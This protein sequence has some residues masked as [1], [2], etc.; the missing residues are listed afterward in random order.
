MIMNIAE[1]YHEKIKK[2]WDGQGQVGWK[3]DEGI[4]PF[5][6]E[7][8]SEYKEQLG[9]DILD[10][11][12]GN[13]RYMMPFVRDGFNVTGLDISQEMLNSSERGLKEQNLEARYIL[14][15][16]VSLPFEN[17]S[18]DFVLSIGTLHHNK[19]DD[20][21]K[22]FN[23]IDRVL[24]PKKHFLFM[25]RSTSDKEFEREVIE[26]YRD[27]GFGFTAIDKTGWKKDLVQ[28]Y[29]NSA[30]LNQLGHEHGFEVIGEP[31]E[32]IRKQQGVQTSRIWAIYKK[33]K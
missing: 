26:D 6:N 25:G 13:G 9:H 20:I 15:N 1:N 7:F 24:R 21:R 4:D 16:S 29:F 33:K 22:S 18:F 11:G 27:L 5:F 10:V 19:M 8:Y 14:G 30:E 31:H 32:Q 12:C 2:H 17:Q 28:H 23:E 3:K